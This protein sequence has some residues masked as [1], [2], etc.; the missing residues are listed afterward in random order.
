[1]AEERAVRLAVGDVQ[2]RQVRDERL[3]RVRRDQRRERVVVDKA[4]DRRAI[5]G[6]EVIRDVEAHL[7]VRP[8]AVTGATNE[9]HPAAHRPVAARREQ[10]ERIGGDE[11]V[12]M[13]A[14][15]AGHADHSL[16]GED[17]LDFGA[18][19][20]PERVGHALG[21]AIAVK[22]RGARR[23]HADVVVGKARG[24]QRLDARCSEQVGIAQVE[25]GGHLSPR[26]VVAGTGAWHPLEQHAAHAR[27][28]GSEHQP[29]VDLLGRREVVL[30][31]RRDRRRLERD[32]ALVDRSAVLRVEHDREAAR[33]RIARERPQ[34][35]VVRQGAAAS[36]HCAVAR[37]PRSAV[38]ST[39]SRL[40]GPAPCS[41]TMSVP[42]KLNVEASSADAARSSA[43]TRRSAG[44]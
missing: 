2:Q 37:R 39:T 14:E 7:R 30:D 29:A 32:D 42:L 31:Q 28:V 25:P 6:R 33:R 21:G 26:E 15:L 38:H 43:S 12:A 13:A 41:W 4:R 22:A 11:A 23:E 16:L 44:G 36:R 35:G 27:R 10:R 20:H 9:R 19:E 24:E 18:A 17:A 40:T 8:G 3:G 1:M 5:A 34:R